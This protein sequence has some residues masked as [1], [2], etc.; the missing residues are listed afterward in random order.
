MLWL[1]TVGQA[2]ATP[3]GW[4]VIHPG[5]WQTKTTIGGQ[6]ISR[7]SC[8]TRE[9]V[10]QMNSLDKSNLQTRQCDDPT[11]SRDDAAF[12]ASFSCPD[13]EYTVRHMLADKDAHRMKTTRNVKGQAADTMI[14]EM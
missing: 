9:M 8:L 6:A 1:T 11:F 13:G 10:V 12:V 2:C 14:S 3:D 5:N 4:P 7:T